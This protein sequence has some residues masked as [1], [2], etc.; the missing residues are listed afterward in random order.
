[1][2]LKNALRTDPRVLRLR[3]VQDFKE[4]RRKCTLTPL[5]GAAGVDFVRLAHPRRCRAPAEQPVQIGGGI[6]LH[7]DGPP[8]TALD[9]ALLEP[10]DDG[11]ADRSVV[12]IDSS[13]ARVAKVLARCAP[14]PGARLER[15]SLPAELSTAYPRKSKLYDD[16]VRGLASIEALYAVTVILGAPRNELL[17]HY[18]WSDE[19]LCR[20]RSV[21]Q[22]FRDASRRC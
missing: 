19:F 18:R 4:N 5:E 20:N 17:T 2:L 15:R 3:V 14:S 21:F 10:N 13:W 22:Q 16:P 11:D 7:V 6:L 12:L 8:L 9:R 1:V